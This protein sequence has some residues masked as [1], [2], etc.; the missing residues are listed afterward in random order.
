M[1]VRAKN[2]FFCQQINFKVAAFD[3]RACILVANIDDRSSF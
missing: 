3:D 2:S 1:T